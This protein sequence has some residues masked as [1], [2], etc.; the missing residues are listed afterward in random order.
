MYNTRFTSEQFGGEI[1]FDK[2]YRT[3]TTPQGE[4]L[5]GVSSKNLCDLNG[6]VFADFSHEQKVESDGKKIAVRVYRSWQYGDFTVK[7]NSLWLGEE[8][9]GSMPAKKK[10]TSLILLGATCILLALTIALIAL[11]DL[12]QSVTTAPVIDVKDDNGS[13]SAQGTIAVLDDKIM[14]GSDGE[15]EFIIRNPHDIRLSYSFT[16]GERYNDGPVENFPLEYRVRVNN[17]LIGSEQ[18]LSATELHFENLLLMAESDY[19][20]SLEWRWPFE[21]A[22]NAVDTDFGTDAGEYSLEFVL[23][24]EAVSEITG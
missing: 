15:Y 3:V 23:T 22:D 11:I 16:I 20:V 6:K 9:L 12:P 1:Q 13:W 21:G 18:W 14:P 17:A 19:L 2:K 5:C 24:A 10:R 4:S 7:E 8:L